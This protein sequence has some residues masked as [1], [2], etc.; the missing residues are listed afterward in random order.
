MTWDKSNLIF[1]ILYNGHMIMVI[2]F[3]V[4]VINVRKSIVFWLP[5][6]MHGGTGV[7]KINDYTYFAG[8]VGSTQRIRRILVSGS[9]FFSKR[10]G[11]P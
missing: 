8:Q 1:E 7:H 11:M 9:R 10:T 2:Y 4:L 3:I 5:I 6:D